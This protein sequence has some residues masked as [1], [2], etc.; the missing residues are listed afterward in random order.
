MSIDTPE[1]FQKIVFIVTELLKAE[2]EIELYQILSDAEINI[3]ENYYD[4]WNGGTSYYCVHVN[5][6]I[7]T[8][9]KIRDKIEKV[10]AEVLSR[11]EISTR[12]RDNENISSIRIIPKSQPKI[13]WNVI[14]GISKKETLLQDIEFIKN[15][16]ISVSTGGQRIQEIND[17]YKSKYN[18]SDNVLQ[19]LK[20]RNPNPYKDL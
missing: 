8:F 20:I 6:D 14:S 12:H 1:E 13:D 10:E 5:I 16:M 7:G 19:K 9:V 4:N 3:E 2:K 15:T 17:Q 18:H 11:F